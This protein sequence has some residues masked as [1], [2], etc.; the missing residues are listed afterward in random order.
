MQN[1]IQDFL[2]DFLLVQSLE[3]GVSGEKLTI[4]ITGLNN[5]ED[6][7]SVESELD[8]IFAIQSRAFNSFKEK[9]WNTILNY[10]KQKHL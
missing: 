3:P 10:F 8:K 6:F 5:F 1:Y 4:T 2:D 7:K 9:R